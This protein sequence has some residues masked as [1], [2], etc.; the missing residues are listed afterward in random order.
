VKRS[1]LTGVLWGVAAWLVYGAVELA[2][3][4]GAQLLQ[5]QDLIVLGWQWRLVAMVFGVYVLAGILLGGTAGALLASSGR[6]EAKGAYATAVT[7]TLILAFIVNSVVAGHLTRSEYIALA[8]ALALVIG[9][10]A[11]LSSEAW[12]GR[13]GFLARPLTASLLLLSIPWLN[14]DVLASESSSLT[15]N[16]LPVFLALVIAGGAGLIWRLR[17]G[18]VGTAMASLVAACAIFLVTLAAAQYKSRPPSVRAANEAPANAV[19]KP[20]VLLITM[21]TVRADHL[22][23]YGYSRDTTPNLREFASAGTIYTRSIAAWDATLPSHA[24]ILTGMYPSWHG[25]FYARPEF[26]YGR[27]LPAGHTTLAEVFSSLGYWTGES[28]ANYSY[29]APWAG[30]TRGFKTVDVDRPAVL[31]TVE[32]P[33]Y[34]RAGAR[35]V[36]G[37]AWNVLAFDRRTLTAEDINERALAMS[38]SAVADHRPFFLFINY[39]DAHSPYIPEAP[40]NSRFPGGDPHFDAQKREKLFRS[41]NDTSKPLSASEY[42]Q[43]VS[44]YD[45]GIAEEDASMGTLFNRLRKLSLFDN[46][47]I[48]VTADHGELFGEHG[49]LEHA[50]GFTYDGLVHTPL[51]IKYPGQHSGSRD[52]EL[53][54][55]ADL[56][57]TILEAVGATEPAGLQGRS[58]LRPHDGPREVYV[59]ATSGGGLVTKNPRFKGFRRSMLDGSLKFTTWTDGPPEFYDL[60]VDPGEE[61]NLYSPHDPRVIDLAKRLETWVGSIPKEKLQRQNL[62]KST[63]ERLKS[64]GYVQ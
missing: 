21:D 55:Q 8:V 43:L 30:L 42:A 10:V 44:Q 1:V 22:S 27:P 14:L 51:I 50:L 9:C 49:L 60:A 11:A 40:F 24:T 62:D 36:L 53:V 18:Q 52:D 46:T 57:P 32:R 64:L 45:G 4:L 41:V 2:L 13:M 17:R 39:M 29:L 37:L 28:A 12:T 31:S 63:L 48:L 58:L 23:V 33:F 25:A 59:E 26:P 3:S 61:H 5:H 7:L 38:S 56:M 15:R 16:A 35:R 20:N 34:L 54:S 47:L 19:G 6:S